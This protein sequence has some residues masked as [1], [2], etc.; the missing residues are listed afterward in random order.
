[1]IDYL[2]SLIKQKAFDKVIPSKSTLNSLS[3][4]TLAQF[5]FVIIEVSLDVIL[6]YR[7]ALGEPLDKLL[8][9]NFKASAVCL[10]VSDYEGLS[11]TL[12]VLILLCVCIRL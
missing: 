3:C 10:A 6:A 7:L 2:V 12:P 8:R 11:E 5:N 1:V 4:Y 9:D